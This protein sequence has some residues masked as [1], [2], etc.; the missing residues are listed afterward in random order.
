[1]LI[2]FKKDGVDYNRPDDIKYQ[3]LQ[4]EFKEK[5][6]KLINELKPSMIAEA[7]SIEVNYA[8]Y[9]IV[10]PILVHGFSTDS[11]Y[12]MLSLIQLAYGK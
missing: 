4:D 2:T 10:L 8:D 12:K 3:Q 6:Y 1:M 9:I 11:H 7:G 5:I